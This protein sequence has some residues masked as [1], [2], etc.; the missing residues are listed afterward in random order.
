MKYL[1]SIILFLNVL[2]SYAAP[3]HVAAETGNL[4][5]VKR[6]LEKGVDVNLPQTDFFDLTPL[7][8]A[9]TGEI[10]EHLIKNGA[11][12]N[13][14]AREGS[15]PLHFAAWNG[16][17]DKV[18]ILIDNGAELNVINN[19]L[20]GFPFQTALE[21]AIFRTNTDIENL[22]RK[23]GGLTSGEL[24]AGMTAM[25]I[26]AK[27]SNLGDIKNLISTG[28]DVN[29]SIIKP[30]KN[31]NKTPLDLA[32]ESN[33]DEIVKYLIKQGAKTKEQIFP[34]VYAALTGEVKNIINLVNSGGDINEKSNDG[35]TPLQ[36][37]VKSEDLE[38]VTF[39][40]DNGAN[41]NHK[42]ISGQT[43]MDFASGDISILI[44]SKGGKTSKELNVLI[45]AAKKG[46]LTVVKNLFLEGAD[47]NAKSKSGITPLHNAAMYGHTD[48]AEYL[49]NNGANI[50][51]YISSGRYVNKTPYDVALMRKKTETA[52]LLRQYGAY[53]SEELLLMPKIAYYKN[54]KISWKSIKNVEY[55]VQDSF[56]LV[57][58][59][60]IKKIKGNGSK[61]YF[62]DERD[63]NPKSIF[64]RI[65]VK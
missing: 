65:F 61:M 17:Y 59:N 52:N 54:K 49:L 50:N 8:W 51:Q 31:I 58:W 43:A 32:K 39:I 6:E 36:N 20:S 33:N 23:N 2:N 30:G 57:E 19:E 1:A 28:L 11:D 18:L 35:T 3:I 21:W 41:V 26:A 42:N 7:H 24:N 40:L 14:I 25:H 10:T 56:N 22:I 45:D 38:M 9:S 4:D 48:V 29:A 46:D 27:N 63:H 53:S 44:K 60:I 16:H 64:Y 5:N 47:I 15:T 62:E 12:I 37:A 13:N 34:M 55:L